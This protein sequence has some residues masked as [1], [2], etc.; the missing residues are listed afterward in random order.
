LTEDGVSAD[1]LEAVGY[2]ED[3]PLQNN[4]TAAGRAANRRVEF[5]VTSA[6]PTPPTPTMP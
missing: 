4:N 6:P 2:G 5:K 1:K 3:M